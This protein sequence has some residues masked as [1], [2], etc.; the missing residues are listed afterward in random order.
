MEDF[1]K[2]QILS[3]KVWGVASAST[4]AGDSQTMLML[5]VW[6]LQLRAVRLSIL[7]CIIKLIY[8]KRLAFTWYGGYFYVSTWL[9]EGMSREL[10]KHHFWVCPWEFFQNRLSFES[11][12]LSEAAH[13]HPCRRASSDPLRVWIEQKGGRKTNSLILLKH[14]FSPTSGPQPPDP[15]ALGL[16]QN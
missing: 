9:D 10:G 12:E 4:P 1:V 15:Q 11:V 2:M 6:G 8:K 13:P 5:L 7:F 14:P 3:Q 16:R